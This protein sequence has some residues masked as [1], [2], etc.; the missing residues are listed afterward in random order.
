MI[1]AFKL[2]LGI[3]LIPVL[4]LLLTAL[5]YLLSLIERPLNNFKARLSMKV[6]NR[7]NATS[8]MLSNLF[9][10]LMIGWLLVATSFMG[11]S[12]VLGPDGLFPC[13][14]C[15]PT[16][17]Q[18]PCESKELQDRQTFERLCNKYHWPECRTYLIGVK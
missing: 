15:M 14:S 9:L 16:F 8:R 10:L 5:I 18:Q 3:I 13:D 4:F 1:C 17:L 7:W 11:I 12:M 6:R 2:L